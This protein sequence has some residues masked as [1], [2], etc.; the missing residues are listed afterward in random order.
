MTY[1]PKPSPLTMGVGVPFAFINFNRPIKPI[2][3]FKLTCKVFID[4]APGNSIRLR[5]LERPSKKI[6]YVNLLIAEIN[7]RRHLF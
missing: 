7:H 1:S 6:F 5:C 2:G 3:H 4:S